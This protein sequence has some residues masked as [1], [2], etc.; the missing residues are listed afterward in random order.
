MEAN[1]RTNN[2]LQTLYLTTKNGVECTTRQKFTSLRSE[3]RIYLVAERKRIARNCIYISYCYG[4]P[5]H[6][7]ARCFYDMFR[8]VGRFSLMS[9]VN[10]INATGVDASLIFNH[11]LITEAVESNLVVPGFNPNTYKLS[12]DL[13]EW[14]KP[15]KKKYLGVPENDE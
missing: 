5:I 1:K 13:W 15:D 11:D 3:G 2:H 8:D 4:I 14:V 7:E 9:I 10:L 12:F 6:S